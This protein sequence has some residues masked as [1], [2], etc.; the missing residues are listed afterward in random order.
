MKRYTIQDYSLSHDE[1]RHITRLQPWPVFLGLTSVWITLILLVVAFRK[2]IAPEFFWWVYIPGIFLIAGRFGAL[3]QLAHEGAHGLLSR[4]RRWNRWV[5]TWLCTYPIGVDFEGYAKQHIQ[6]HLY[7]N[8]EKDSESDVEKY[9]F[10]DYR[11]PRL[12]LLFLKDLLGITALSI[13]FKYQESGSKEKTGKELKR[14][15]EKFVSLALVQSFILFSFFGADV[16]DYLLLWI[17]PAISPHMF[18]M[19]IRGIAEHGL[20]DQLGLTPLGDPK[21][22]Q[23]YTRSFFT[24]QNRYH[25]ILAVWV[26][27]LLIGSFSVNYHHEHHLLTTVPFYRLEAFHRRIAPEVSRR[28]PEVYAPGYFAAAFRGLLGKKRVSDLNHRSVIG[29]G[30]G[31]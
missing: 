19:R 14:K 20:A 3:I 21:M 15:L 28:Y 29:T 5:A 26:E 7:T 30:V 25:L 10:T 22:G 8:T 1:V 6:H 16:V 27:R 31:V 17:V 11:S 2:A 4:N 12:Y 9:A 13:F 18:L 24:S 23:I